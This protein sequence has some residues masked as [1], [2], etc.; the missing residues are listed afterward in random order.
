M[1]FAA[2]RTSCSAYLFPERRSVRQFGTGAKGQGRAEFGYD[3]PLD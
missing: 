2:C 1:T 3:L